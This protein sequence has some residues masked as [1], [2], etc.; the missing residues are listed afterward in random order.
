[1]LLVLLGFV[2]ASVALLVYFRTFRIKLYHAKQMALVYAKTLSLPL[3]ILIHQ[4]VPSL[5]DPK[6]NTFRPHWLLFNGHLQTI[7]S[8][9]MNKCYESFG[10]QK[11]AYERQII[12]LVD[13]GI[14]AID[15]SNYT[16]ECKKLLVILH[17]VTGGSR[18]AYIQDFVA[19]CNSMDYA[20]VVIN[21]RGCGGTALATPKAYCGDSTQDILECINAIKLKAP[22]AKLIGVGFSLGS[23]VLLKLAAQMGQKCCF[24][25]VVSLGNPY[26]LLGSL[27]NM[28]RTFLGSIYSA[29]IAKN[30]INVALKFQKIFVK[31]NIDYH[32]L[33]KVH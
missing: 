30:L 29:A 14:M 24:S 1:M 8:A 10:I 33:V 27:R 28:D 32:S 15:W 25:A 16:K 11:V 2:L 20:S 23:N 22:C 6:F 26:C 17:G 31:S 4:K 19:H 12:K 7:Y 18:E 9:L 21:F 13:G 3:D 5:T